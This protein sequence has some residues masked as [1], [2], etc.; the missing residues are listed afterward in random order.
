MQNLDLTVPFHH[1]WQHSVDNFQDAF[2]VSFLCI[3]AK[4]WGGEEGR[5]SHFDD[6]ACLL[7]LTHLRYQKWL[8]CHLVLGRI[9]KNVEC[10]STDHCQLALIVT[11]LG[12]F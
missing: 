12:L 4:V 7:D 2:P 8:D 10:F 5:Q 11:W 6:L 9:K 1:S 3:D